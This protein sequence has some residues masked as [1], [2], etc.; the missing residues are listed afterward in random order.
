MSESGVKSSWTIGR[1]PD[2]D[3]VVN[4]PAVSS[5]H[6]RLSLSDSG[7]RIEDLKSAN[8]TYVNGQRVAGVVPVFSEDVVTL[9]KTIPFPWPDE[10]VSG[11]R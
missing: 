10:A 11:T 1:A 7:L 5:H 4:N 3:I 6:C 2:C 8:G 9:G